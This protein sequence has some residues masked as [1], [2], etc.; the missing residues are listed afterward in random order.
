A[1]MMQDAQHKV[2]VQVRKQ[3]VADIYSGKEMQFAL[4]DFVP[5]GRTEKIIYYVVRGGRYGRIWSFAKIA[6]FVRN[7]FADKFHMVSI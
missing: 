3:H 5:Q 7:H 4:K 2:P 1:Q 6:N